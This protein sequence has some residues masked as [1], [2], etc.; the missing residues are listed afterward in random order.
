MPCFIYSTPML[1]TPFRQFP[2]YPTHSRDFLNEAH[3]HPTDRMTFRCKA[4]HCCSLVLPNSTLVLYY[5]GHPFRKHLSDHVQ[6]ILDISYLAANRS[7]SHPIILKQFWDWNGSDTSVIALAFQYAQVSPLKNHV[8]GHLILAPDTY[9]LARNL[10][11][12]YPIVPKHFRNR[13]GSDTSVV[14][15]AFCMPIC[16]S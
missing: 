10:S 11:D 1:P 16:S 3:D 9:R 8:F 15:P 5:A 2:A 4:Q 7:G 6:L 13:S 14:A 12:S